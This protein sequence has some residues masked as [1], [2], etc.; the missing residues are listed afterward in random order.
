MRLAETRQP[1]DSISSNRIT[2]RSFHQKFKKS[3]R[4][5]YSFPTVLIL[6]FVFFLGTETFSIMLSDTN[7]VCNNCH[8]WILQGHVDAGLLCPYCG[9]E[10]AERCPHC[11]RDKI[12]T[13]YHAGERVCTSCGIV[14]EERMMFSELRQY[15]DDFDGEDNVRTGERPSTPTMS[16]SDRCFIPR[17]GRDDDGCRDLSKTATE[18]QIVLNRHKTVHNEDD[19]DTSET[20]KERCAKKRKLYEQSTT[21]VEGPPTSEKGKERCAKKRKLYEHACAE[22][23]GPP[24][25]EK[26]KGR[27]AKKRKRGKQ[28]T[29]EVEGPPTSE[30]GKER[31]GKKRRRGEIEEEEEESSLVG[32]GD[33]IDEENCS[34]DV[35]YTDEQTLVTGDNGERSEKEMLSE[36]TTTEVE[37]PARKR[38]RYNRGEKLM[39]PEQ[40]KILL[41]GEVRAFL[42]YKAQC[43][44]KNVSISKYYQE[45]IANA[46]KG[47]CRTSFFDALKIVREGSTIQKRGKPYLLTDEEKT[48]LVTRLQDFERKF[49]EC[50]TNE[51]IKQEAG[52][53]VLSRLRNTKEE[54]REEQWRKKV[55]PALQSVFKRNFVYSFRKE[56]LQ[57]I[58]FSRKRNQPWFRLHLNGGAL[59][60]LHVM[61]IF[62][63]TSCMEDR[64]LVASKS[65]FKQ[66]MEVVND[67]LTSS[68]VQLNES[69][70]VFLIRAK[71]PSLNEFAEMLKTVDKYCMTSN[72]SD[73]SDDENNGDFMMGQVDG[74][75]GLD[76]EHDRLSES[77]RNGKKQSKMVKNPLKENNYA[78]DEGGQNQCLEFSMATEDEEEGYSNH[79]EDLKK[80]NINEKIPDNIEAKK[81]NAEANAK[82]KTEAKATEEKTKKAKTKEKKKAKAKT[83]AEAKADAEAKAMTKAEAKTNA[84]AKAKATEKENIQ[85][86]SKK[87]KAKT[88]TETKAK[89]KTKTE[90]KNEKEAAMTIIDLENANEPDPV[91]KGYSELISPGKSIVDEYIVVA[92]L[93]F[94]VMRIPCGGYNST[95][96]VTVD[97]TVINNIVEDEQ[98][99]C[100]GAMDLCAGAMAVQ[101]C[102]KGIILTTSPSLCAF[103]AS[104]CKSEIEKRKLFV[105][106]AKSEVDALSSNNASEMPHFVAMAVNSN[107]NH[108]I[109][110][111]VFPSTYTAEYWDSLGTN[112]RHAKNG[113]YWVKHLQEFCED[114][115]W[116]EATSEA[117]AKWR[118]LNR[119]I[120][121]QTNGYDCGR[122]CLWN[123]YELGR[124]IS[125]LSPTEDVHPDTLNI[126]FRESS[127]VQSAEGRQE[128]A[129]ILCKHVQNYMQTKNRKE[130]S[131]T[132]PSNRDEL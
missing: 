33:E 18:S 48:T 96:S 72:E 12:I 80:E 16:S 83:K 71:N 99:M 78:G 125:T 61:N 31:R 17:V 49:P 76:T 63:N 34:D 87:A 14:V 15:S 39:D 95:D 103:E 43:G 91:A 85:E 55:K 115:K 93:E 35:Q 114:M 20:A 54:E 109:V 32:D 41:D 98:W 7:D 22:V 86:K 131:D 116:T 58:E 130:A 74:E 126:Q 119:K 68:S 117:R 53:I 89:T 19:V 101:F 118:L 36:Q 127:F 29:T 52:E 112:S 81:S 56:Y 45:R 67:L 124:C 77:E 62:G 107:R 121:H 65:R 132:S 90:T 70:M 102:N 47:P 69:K 110:I 26:G 5:D 100:S 13:K 122:F 105:K 113:K 66:E 21:E 59:R 11:E 92:N 6:S 50:L 2:K 79:A 46:K 8:E 38:R 28:S 82:A 73:E 123:L 120:P 42:I 84:E 37:G 1:I 40:A 24:T 97:A 51:V 9:K 27:C 75:Q 108:W 94:P 44:G 4:S 64:M 57:E 129:V 106:V 128:L 104:R 3:F 60:Q 23:E 10:T 25:S 30:K 111:T 88:K